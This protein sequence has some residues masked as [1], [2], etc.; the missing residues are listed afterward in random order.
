MA[1]RLNDAGIALWVLMQVPETTNLDGA[2]NFLTL[3]RFPGWNE[4]P[5][6]TIT[7]EQHLERQR[8]GIQTFQGLEGP[9]LKVIDASESFFH[10]ASGRLTVYSER[11]HYWEDDHLTRYGTELYLRPRLEELFQQIKLH[12]N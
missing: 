1:Q 8:F 11:S 9:L 6:E 12:H 7:L 4:L 5:S 3:R 10:A 2:Q